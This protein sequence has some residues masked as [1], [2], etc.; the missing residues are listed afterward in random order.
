MYYSF[1]INAPGLENTAFLF[2]RS[3]IDASGNLETAFLDNAGP[4]TRHRGNSIGQLAATLASD[5]S[6][7]VLAVSRNQ[8]LVLDP[9]LPQRIAKAQTELAPLAERWS[10]AAAGGLT[11]SGVRVCALYSSETPFIPIH[12][13][14]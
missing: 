7:E 6:I 13:A 4:L 2:E 8:D 1:K 12:S 9:G 10:L 11:P 5:R 3:T 14:P